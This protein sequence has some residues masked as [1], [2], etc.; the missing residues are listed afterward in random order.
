MTCVGITYFCGGQVFDLFGILVVRSA[1]RFIDY[2]YE[3]I[4][5]QIGIYRFHAIINSFSPVLTPAFSD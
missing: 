3:R 1:K 2:A 5:A 4:T